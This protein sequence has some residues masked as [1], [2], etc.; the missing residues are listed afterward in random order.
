MRIIRSLGQRAVFSLTVHE[1]NPLLWA[2][3]GV[4]FDR[5]RDSLSLMGRENPSIYRPE[6]ISLFMTRS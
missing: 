6:E 3:R 1:D 5:P 4:L 2:E